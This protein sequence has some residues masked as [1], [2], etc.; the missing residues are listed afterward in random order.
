[1]AMVEVG[2]RY[3]TGYEQRGN[4][5]GVR[6]RGDDILFARITPCLENGKLA[7]LPTDA[8]PTGGSTEFIV[9]RP[10][11]AVDP[12]FVYYWCMSPSVRKAAE[13][14]MTGTTGRMRLAGKDLA[15]LV[16]NYPQLDEQRRIVEILEDHLSRLD[17]GMTELVMSI[18]R[19]NAFRQS[20]LVAAMRDAQASA[21]NQ[22]ML[23]GQLADVSTGMTPLKSNKTYY[24]GG[25]I[26]WITS[27]DL[28]RGVVDTASQFVTERALAETSLK[29]LP[30]GAILVA[31]YGEGRTRGTAAELAIAATTN[32]ACAAVVLQDPELR[33][34][35]RLV[36]DANYVALRRMA[37]GG[38]QPNLNLS[39]V[40]GMEI[41][42]PPASVRSAILERVANAEAST[43]KMRGALD[44]T[45]A[46]AVNLRRSLLTAA[47][48]GRLTRDRQHLNTE[49]LVTL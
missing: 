23:L 19:L 29:L 26:A 44:A 24:E 28:H 18:K 2:S 22:R 11:P 1:M 49:E 46:R 3:P 6:A 33:P 31:M 8:P 15:G 48:S 30:A 32:Q 5:G 16:L 9:V 38:V 14:R 25:T 20:T 41:P 12:G 40:R 21:G 42:I 7:Q 17:A 10:G 43:R 36:L 45:S 27:G 34:W 35:V 47:F 4:R 39:I 13:A 37:A